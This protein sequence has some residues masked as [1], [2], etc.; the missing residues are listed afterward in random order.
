MIVVNFLEMVDYNSIQNEFFNDHG[1]CFVWK[2]PNKI[3]I[4]EKNYKLK[5]N[6]NSSLFVG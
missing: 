3:N 4:F 5:S 2:I 1:F 6:N